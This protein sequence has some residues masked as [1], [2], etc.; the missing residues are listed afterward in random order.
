MK[1]NTVKV[2]SAWFILIASYLVQYDIK[3]IRNIISL[4]NCSM[5]K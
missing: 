1:K 5:I 4:L 3:I 2:F